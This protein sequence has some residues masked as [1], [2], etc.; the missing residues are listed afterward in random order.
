MSG[1]RMSDQY[2]PEP[3]ERSFACSDCGTLQGWLAEFPGG[4]CIDCHDV[5]TRGVV[6]TAADLR[7]AFGG[8]R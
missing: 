7:A 4:R 2:R 6:V 3:G 8:R 1:A 5:A